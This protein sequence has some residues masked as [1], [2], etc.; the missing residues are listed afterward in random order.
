VTLAERVQLVRADEQCAAVTRKKWQRE[1]D[2]RDVRNT[3]GP[4]RRRRTRCLA[5]DCERPVRVRGYC[6]MHWMRIS[7]AGTIER[8]WPDPRTA[9]GRGATGAKRN[10]TLHGAT[11]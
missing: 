1:P 2:Q 11:P 6:H 10:T 5:G 8:A 9:R 4:Q 7:T 3:K